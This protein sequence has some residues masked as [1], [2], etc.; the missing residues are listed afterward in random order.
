MKR[1]LFSTFLSILFIVSVFIISIVLEKYQIIDLETSNLLTVPVRFPALIYLY[2]FG[3]PVPESDLMGVLVILTLML[4]EI[5]LYALI[6]Y[7]L[8][9][10][11]FRNKK[12]IRNNPPKPPVF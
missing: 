5:I 8:I 12:E 11:V 3:L 2:I 4:F 9:F 10:F 1:I 6:I 7:G